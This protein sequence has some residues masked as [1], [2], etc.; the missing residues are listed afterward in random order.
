MMHQTK[1]HMGK[2]G[3]RNRKWSRG[4]GRGAHLPDLAGQVTLSQPGGQI[5]L[6]HDYSPPTPRRF[7]DLPLSLGNVESQSTQVSLFLDP[8]VSYFV[9]IKAILGNRF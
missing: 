2:Q 7:L 5:M 8:V 9:H 1:V 4:G 3:Y 6:P